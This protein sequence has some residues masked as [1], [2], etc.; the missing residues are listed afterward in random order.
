[1]SPDRIDHLLNAY[2]DGDGARW[3]TQLNR[4]AEFYGALLWLWEAS[5]P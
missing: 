2:F 5:R 3:Q 4:Q 1:L